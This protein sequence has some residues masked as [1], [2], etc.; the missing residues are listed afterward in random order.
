MLTCP[1]A[2]RSDFISRISSSWAQNWMNWASTSPALAQSTETG[3][4]ME[5]CACGFTMSTLHTANELLRLQ[6]RSRRHAACHAV[7]H[8][9]DRLIPANMLQPN[10]QLMRS[11]PAWE[12]VG[13]TTGCYRVAEA[14]PAAL[15]TLPCRPQ[16]AQDM[17]RRPDSLPYAL[18]RKRVGQRSDVEWV[19][20]PSG[21][22]AGDGS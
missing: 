10:E 8:L 3:K 16:L 5:A 22:R 4:V 20:L 17:Q 19:S 14:A 7:H 1:L 2:K 13:L 6:A 11:L 9:P 18:R 15:G 21:F 12:G